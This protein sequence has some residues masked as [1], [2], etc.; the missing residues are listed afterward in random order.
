MNA[1]CKILSYCECTKGSHQKK[2]SDILGWKEGATATAIKR[3]LE[4]R[5]LEKTERGIYRTTESGKKYVAEMIKTDIED[6]I[7]YFDSKCEGW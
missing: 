7:R 3:L 5:L 1:N 6:L 4:K 2:I